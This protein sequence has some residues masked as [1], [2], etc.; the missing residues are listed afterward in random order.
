MAE[1]L[2]LLKAQLAAAVKKS[3]VLMEQLDGAH[4]ELAVSQSDFGAKSEKIAEL[5]AALA[6]AKRQLKVCRLLVDDADVKKAECHSSC[7]LCV[8]QVAK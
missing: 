4:A 1:Q 5:E 8:L 6:E 7:V 2:E 3:A